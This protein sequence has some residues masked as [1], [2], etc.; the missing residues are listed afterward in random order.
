MALRDLLLVTHQFPPV[1]GSGV[2]RSVKL[3]KYLPAAGWRP[4][5]LCAGDVRHP[6][7][8]HSLLEDV[9][10]DA[11]VHRIRGFEPA[12]V[13][14]AF[15]G[16]YSP[17]HRVTKWGRWLEERLSWRMD[18][19]VAWLKLPETALLWVPSA[20]RAARR[21]IGQYPI[22][23]VVT[24]SPANVS[25][26]VGLA[27]KRRMGVP[28]IADLRDP[29]VGNFAHDPRATFT[30]RF[31]RRLESDVVHRA[32]RI[33][34]TC[35]E[36]SDALSTCHPDAAAGRISTITNG[37]DAADAPPE[38]RT[39]L[40]GSTS[41]GE[42]RSTRS[43]SR[44]FVLAH[45]GA[46]YR[47]QSIGPVLEAIRS[48]RADRPD[49]AQ[50]LEFRLVGSLS[51]TQSALLK[52]GDEQFFTRVGY[53]PHGDSIREMSSAAALILATPANAGGRLCIPAKTFEYLAF[54]GHIIASVHSGTVLAKILTDAGNVTLVTDRN[55]A[56]LADAIRMRFDR[57]RSG[58]PDRPRN[59]GV[60]DRFRR[61]RLARDYAVVLEQC[62]RGT[63]GLRLTL[64]RVAE[65]AA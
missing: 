27:L 26:L 10:R 16:F 11:I 12:G 29:I 39:S 48:L 51:A 18:R 50:R 45:V 21:L 57:W 34:T 20:I 60:V 31:W 52:P 36:L 19:A 59:R 65:D 22:E 5:I 58:I 1:G 6:L 7:M 37:F 17:R 40:R 38:A 42:S 41:G 14:A 35:P 23:A 24:T 13:A 64:E 49:I 47:Q 44:R 43:T 55:P 53:L 3:A 56:A 9:G 62:V 54:G 2:Q 4:H 15:C 32:D 28:W 46:F 61:D 30:N 33:V 25:H 63:S 8:D